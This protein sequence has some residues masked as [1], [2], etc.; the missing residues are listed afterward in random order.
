MSLKNEPFYTLTWMYANLKFLS[1]FSNDE[2]E[3][4]VFSTEFNEFLYVKN[5]AFLKITVIIIGL[6]IPLNWKLN[7]LMNKTN[8]TLIV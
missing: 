4:E 7:Q 5:L 6:K 3:D 8:L 2:F 1:N